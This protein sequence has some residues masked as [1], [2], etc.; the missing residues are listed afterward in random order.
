[1]DHDDAGLTLLIYNV[2]YAYIY[3][4]H[5]KAKRAGCIAGDKKGNRVQEKQGSKCPSLPGF[6]HWVNPGKPGL[7]FKPYF[8]K[9]GEYWVI[10]YFKCL[11]VQNCANLWVLI[12]KNKE[13]TRVVRKVLRLCQY[14]KK[15]SSLKNKTYT[16]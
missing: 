10:K 11:D 16:I 14:L 6:T 15:Y 1:M 2:W 3:K 13:H 5:H 12:I 7:G 9:S 4:G 8:G